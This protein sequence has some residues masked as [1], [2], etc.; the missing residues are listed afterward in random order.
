VRKE[1]LFEVLGELDDDIVKEAKTTMTKKMNW[2][3]WVAMAACLCLVVIAAATIPFTIEPSTSNDGGGGHHIMTPGHDADITPTL[4]ADKE[5][6][7]EMANEIADEDINSWTEVNGST[8]E[9]D[10]TL[11][12][13]VTLNIERDS[14]TVLE[15][16]VFDNQ[17]MI[18]AMSDSTCIG[19]FTIVKFEDKW[20][21]SSYIAGLDIVQLIQSN[22]DD[23]ACLVN[24]PQLNGEYGLLK[25]SNA[26]EEYTP[27]PGFM[28]SGTESGEQLLK[29]VKR[30]IQ[31]GESDGA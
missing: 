2:K 15:T 24:V 26:G 13:Y 31:T 5:V 8:F 18:P 14:N 28:T 25:V 20:T 17:Y 21:I 19:A 1:E 16:L 30:H 10:Y 11:P 29:D 6:I 7:N 23:A 3:V 27:V 9:F 4:F 22:K 12:I